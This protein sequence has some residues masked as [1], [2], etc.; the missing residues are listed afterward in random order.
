MGELLDTYEQ[1][2]EN[3]GLLSQ[4][5]ALFHTKPHMVRVLSLLYEDLLDFHRLALDY[6]QQPG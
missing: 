4:Y 5:E 1:M 6:F 3:I 2:G